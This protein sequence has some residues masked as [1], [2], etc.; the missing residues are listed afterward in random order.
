MNT[1]DFAKQEGNNSVEGSMFLKFASPKPV[2]QKPAIGYQERSLFPVIPATELLQNAH[3]QPLLNQIRQAIVM[4]G[5]FYQ[6]LYTGL[7]ANFASYVQVVPVTAGGP[8]G[9]MLDEGLRRALYAVQLHLAE[10]KE[11]DADP[12]YTYAIF[13]AA[14]LLDLRKLLAN[15]KIILANEQG[16]FLAEW[17]PLTGPMTI[18]DCYKVRSYARPMSQLSPYLTPLLA[19]QVMPEQ[20][21]LWLS[22]DL[23]LL[24]MW[25]AALSGDEDSAGGIGHFLDLAKKRLR[26]FQE[27]LP[28]LIVPMTE[29]QA[30]AL[31]EEFLSWLKKNANEENVIVTKEG[32]L[33]EEKIF[34]DFCRATK[35]SNHLA[36]RQQVVNALGL[37]KL[38]GDDKKIEQL[39]SE[40]P[41]A[42]VVKQKTIAAESAA[43]ETKKTQAAF[44][45]TSTGQNFIAGK[46][47]ATESILRRGIVIDRGFLPI[48]A[49]LAINE[50]IKAVATIT[51]NNQHMA[52]LERLLT[53]TAA[54][55]KV[56]NRVR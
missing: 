29:P 4:P 25:L 47:A 51:A 44:F 7:I 22:E 54:N 24:N 1:P 8:L 2:A 36:V 5:E 53:T 19:R 39:F 11:E 27:K 9:S 32:V 16:E 42:K 14:L 13:S 48:T 17:S 34:E 49:K 28:I 46:P 18:G 20:A 43:N 3:W 15:K 21:F 23:N 10:A 40:H 37:A 38:S 50:N 26:Q 41:D 52:S 31:G 30:V 33:L 12:L 45:N 6:E 56:Q 55:I 35:Y